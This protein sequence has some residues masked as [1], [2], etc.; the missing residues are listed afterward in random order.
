MRPASP[1][2]LTDGGRWSGRAGERDVRMK[3][4]FRAYVDAPPKQAVQSAAVALEHSPHEL[5]HAW[6][7]PAMSANVPLGQEA[8]QEPPS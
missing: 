4:E 8:T 7:V 5:S 3:R 6:Q 2:G 1:G